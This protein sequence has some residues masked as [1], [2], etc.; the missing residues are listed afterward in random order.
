[1]TPTWTVNSFVSPFQQYPDVSRMS[2]PELDDFLKACDLDQ[3]EKD[4]LRSTPDRNTYY[5]KHIFWHRLAVA[6]KAATTNHAFLMKSGIFLS[7][8]MKEKFST[9]DTL[10]WEALEE[11]EA[12]ETYDIK[13]RDRG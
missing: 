13:P 7:A 6:R 10:I 2:G 12:N 5:Q 3:W 4:E 1:M 11:H 8:G 9:I